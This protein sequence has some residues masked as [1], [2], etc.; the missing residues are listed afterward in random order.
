MDD[1]DVKVN[2]EDTVMKD[3]TRGRE[4]SV[5][6]EYHNRLLNTRSHICELSTVAMVLR[7]MTP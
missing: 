7:T 6:F 3:E 5:G 4:L 2:G 1:V